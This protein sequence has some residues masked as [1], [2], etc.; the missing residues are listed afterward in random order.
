MATHRH[1]HLNHGRIPQNLLPERVQHVAIPC[2]HAP[3]HPRPN[4]IHHLHN[5]SG[6]WKDRVSD[7]GYKYRI[8]QLVY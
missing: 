1:R 3:H 4:R 5:Y 7:D 8:N 2:R 6:W